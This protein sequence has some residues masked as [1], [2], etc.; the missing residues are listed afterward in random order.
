MKDKVLFWL[1]AEFTHF[2]LA[3]YM[4]KMYDCDMFAIID[5]T[6]KPKK[7]FQEQQ[8]VNFKKK[9]FF[10]DHIQND[11]KPDEQFLSEFEKKYK[12]NLWKLAINERIFYRFYDFHKFTSSE[13]LSILESECK[14]FEN[15]LDEIKPDFFITKEPSFHHLELFYQM[16]RARGVKVLM[17]SQPNVGYRCIISEEASRLDSFDELNKIKITN[18][19]F[20]ELQEYL[21][22]FDL[23]KQLRT[24]DKKHAD[25]TKGWATAAFHYLFSSDNENI[26]THYNYYGRTKYKVILYMLSVLFKKKYRQRFID[27]N[28]KK[29]VDLSIPFVYFPM[30][31]DLERNLL[32]NAPLYTNQIEIIRNIARSLPIGYALYVKENPSQVSR[33][34]RSISEYKEIMLIPNVTLI[35]PSIP[36]QQLLQKCSLVVTISGSSGFEA[37]FYGK[38]TISFANVGYSVLSSVKKVRDVEQLPQLIKTVLEEQVNPSDL[39]RYL[40]LLEKN[41]FDFDWFGFGSEF[42]DKFYFGGTL[43]DVDVSSDQI[44]AFLEEHNEP[45]TLLS[46]EHIKRIKQHREEL[47]LLK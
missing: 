10:H 44:K 6:N 22:S 11:L 32:I 41:S 2:S 21:K 5:I 14:L 37:A 34:W 31:V 45:L 30:A 4:Q 20:E 13:I 15:I 8:L 3:Y 25:S 7:F 46:S 33:E 16:C 35:H 38:P 18:K 1:G 24:Y 28:L 23:S 29:H 40:I 12:I 47:N 9:W 19:N 42:K 43:V 26:K 36:A 27:K 39:E 17:L